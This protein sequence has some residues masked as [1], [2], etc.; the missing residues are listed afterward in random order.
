MK[1]VREMSVDE[2]RE[3]ILKINGRFQ[4]MRSF[5]AIV[6]IPAIIKDSSGRVLYMNP[7]AELM[8]DTT[9]AKAF[10]EDTSHFHTDD[11]AVGVATHEKKVLHSKK[12]HVFL[13]VYLRRG[14]R[15]RYTALSFLFTDDDDNF[16]LGWLAVPQSHVGGCATCL[17]LMLSK[18]S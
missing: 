9:V 4:I 5:M 10:G 2:L 17:K 1:K 15:E 12:P 13:N 3:A 16:Y 11:E 18:L 7:L 8:F 14:K 6:P